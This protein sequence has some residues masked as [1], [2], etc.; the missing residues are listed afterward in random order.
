M[1][2][3][4]SICSLHVA[5]P[6]I[7]I[8]HKIQL[9]RKINA[10]SSKQIVLPLVTSTVAAI[11]PTTVWSEVCIVVHSV[12]SQFSELYAAGCILCLSIVCNSEV[13]D[14]VYFTWKSAQRLRRFVEKNLSQKNGNTC[15]PLIRPR[16]IKNF[17][18]RFWLVFGKKRYRHYI[19]TLGR[20]QNG[21]LT[22]S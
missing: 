17:L 16:G 1:L 4:R 12:T 14:F 5:R 2:S 7:C 22:W 18:M 6:F 3:N 21:D 13:F 19:Y 20:L 15:I 9:T 10:S 11:K 8:K